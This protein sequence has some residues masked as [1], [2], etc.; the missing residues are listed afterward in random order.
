M[1]SAPHDSGGSATG[2]G[3]PGPYQETSPAGMLQGAA[4]RLAVSECACTRSRWRPMAF[5]AAGVAGRM[6]PLS[7]RLVPLARCRQKA[8]WN[9]LLAGKSIVVLY[10]TGTTT[11]HFEQGLNRRCNVGTF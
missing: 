8:P 11:D 7:S 6:P 3:A 9:A 5:A 1:F 2:G 10:R 4:L